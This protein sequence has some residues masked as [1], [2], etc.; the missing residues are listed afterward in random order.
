M[1]A[2]PLELAAIRR[3]AR[4]RTT[5]ILHGFTGT[6][7]AMH[8]LADSLPGRVVA[9]DLLG[10]GASPAPG[11]VDAYR[12]EAQVG[13]VLGLVSVDGTDAEPMDVVGYSM[14]ARLAL[15]LAIAHPTRIRRLALIGATAGLASA[16][17]RASRVAADE[18][19]ADQIE[20]EGIDWF[21]RHWEAM[22]LF[23]SQQ[24][25]PASVRDEVRAGR[26]AQ[27][28]LGLA[29]SLRG[30]G[31]GVM[32]SLWHRLADLELPT[33][34]VAGARDPKYVALAGQMA[35]LLPDASMEVV[36]G[37]GHACHLEA[38]E[39]VAALVVAHFSA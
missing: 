7:Q 39:T 29:N 24:D 18:A 30:F 1:G 15:C 33:L 28:S 23:S 9:P 4:G 13:Q 37:V 12:A 8:A 19:L 17:E 36:A 5:V 6:G 3:G 26:L 22:P 38:P 16:S 34:L 10:H 2:K 20:R 35:A 11:A 14:G 21:V 32:P 27:R 31:T 25:L